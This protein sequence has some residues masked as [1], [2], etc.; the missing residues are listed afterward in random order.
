MRGWK[1]T[2]IGYLR[3]PNDQVELAPLVSVGKV[4]IRKRSERNSWIKLQAFSLRNLEPDLLNNKVA[5]KYKT[6]RPTIRYVYI[7]DIFDYALKLASGEPTD[8]RPLD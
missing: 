5:V 3:D 7:E 6:I 1:E 8:H 2:D 4:I